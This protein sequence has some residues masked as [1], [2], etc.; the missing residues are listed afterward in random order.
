ML[1]MIGNYENHEKMKHGWHERRVVWGEGGRGG[2][3][4]ARP[5][6]PPG[7]QTGRAFGG[8]TKNWA[9]GGGGFGIMESMEGLEQ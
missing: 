9:G 2:G 6:F 4:Q 7:L 5:P 8:L 1:K 3:A